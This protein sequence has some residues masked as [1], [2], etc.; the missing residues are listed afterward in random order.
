MN[1]PLRLLEVDASKF[2]E[3][4][5][6]RQR[7]VNAGTWPA[8]SPAIE[9]IRQ[10]KW[11]VVPLSDDDNYPQVL[12]CGVESPEEAGTLA[13]ESLADGDRAVLRV[14]SLWCAVDLEGIVHLSLIHI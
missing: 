4:R 13:G 11:Q 14:D 1:Q 12:L 6:R 9:T 7:D 8:F 3:S 10:S 2:Q 5:D